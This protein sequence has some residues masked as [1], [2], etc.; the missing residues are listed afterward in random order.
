MQQSNQLNSQ[1][2]LRLSTSRPLGLVRIFRDYRARGA[3]APHISLI[4]VQIRVFM[5]KYGHI[6]VIYALYSGT[7]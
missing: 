4:W 1:R 6:Y 5:P 7:L 3:R 2:T